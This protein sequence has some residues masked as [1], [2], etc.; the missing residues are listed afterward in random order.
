MN[1]NILKKI[2]LFSALNNK[3]FAE[4]AVYLKKETYPPH[5]T[6]FWMDENGDHLYIVLNGKV[7]IG[8]TDENGKEIT[9][10]ML[11]PG[12]FFGE[13]SLIDGGLHS[14][15]ARTMHETV[16]LTLDRDSFYSFLNTHPQVCY[17]LLE[18]LTA[19]LRNI[20]LKM[21][22][23]VNSNE[24]LEAKR[25]TFQHFI[26]NLAKALTSGVF[27]T[28]YI[29]FILGWIS[30][31]AL[32]WKKTHPGPISFSDQPPTFFILGFL[33]TLT[34]FLLTVLILN[35]QRREAENDRIRGEIEYRVNLK[36]Q[37]EVMKMQLKI[38][39]LVEL[40]TELRNEE[41]PDDSTGVE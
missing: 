29:L 1:E 25:S 36:S 10:N 3:G 13:L 22:G 14:A 17:T 16:L 5:H 2:P 6:I 28:L 12:S 27:L 31:Q 21:S 30:V 8:Y 40:I 24:Q 23:V 39:R 18:V 37:A 38:D 15:T 9:L 20:T 19:R 32:L 34:S 26:D 41:S 35:S 11:G 33:I 4:L 7:H